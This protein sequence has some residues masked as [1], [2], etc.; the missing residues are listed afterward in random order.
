MSS[1]GESV[2]DTAKSANE[3]SKTLKESNKQKSRS[4]TNSMQSFLG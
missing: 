3:V 4:V 1:L 2:T